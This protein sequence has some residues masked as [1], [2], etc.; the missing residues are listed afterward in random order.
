MCLS[1]FARDLSFSKMDCLK[2]PVQHDA[3]KNDDTSELGDTALVLSDKARSMFLVESIRW[4]TGT[5]VIL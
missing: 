3:L 5:E 2:S 4:G 1:V